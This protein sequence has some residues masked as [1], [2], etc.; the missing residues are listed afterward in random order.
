M[1]KQRLIRAICSRALIIVFWTDLP[2]SAGNKVKIIQGAVVTACAN[3]S[4]HLTQSSLC[5]GDYYPTTETVALVHFFRCTGLSS[6]TEC[7]ASVLKRK[8]CDNTKSSSMVHA[9][10]K[11][12]SQRKTK[13]SFLHVRQ[14]TNEQQ[15]LSR[16]GRSPV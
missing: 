4:F 15:L 14:T 9:F 5:K 6:C 3:R 11:G 7:I 8:V 16:K 2:R 13:C 10:Q 12:V 1:A